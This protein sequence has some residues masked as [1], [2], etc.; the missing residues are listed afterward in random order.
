ML[1]CVLC[2][3]V[4]VLGTATVF[5]LLALLL[6]Y[7]IKEKKTAFIVVYSL[8]VLAN[9]LSGIFI[10]DREI[11][12][13]ITEVSLVS[14]AMALPYLLLK[15]KKRL[16][17]VWF[18]LIICS[19]FDYLESLVISFFTSPSEHTAQIVYIVLYGLTLALILAAYRFAK[20]RIPAD[21]LEQISPTIYVVIF[22]ADYSAYYD[23]MLSQNSGYH[24]EVSNVLKLLSAALI[25]ACFSYIIYRYSSL[26]YKQRESELQLEAELKHYEEM[27]QKNRDIRTFRHDYKNNLYSLKTLIASGRTDEAEKYIDELDSGLAVSENRYATGNYL[28]DAII[29]GKADEA[30]Q[31]GIDI[32]FDGVIP[33]SGI[34]NNDLCTI[35]S[36]ALD[37][38]V[39]ACAEIAPCKIIINSQITAN[40]ASIRI[41][42]PVKENVE[43]KNN[44]VKTTKN[45]KT[46]HGIG[47]SNIKKAAKKYSGYVELSCEDRIFTVEIGLMLK[48]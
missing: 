48:N 44:S 3:A 9:L 16:T 23:V 35:L 37:N 12:E 27:V 5:S 42:N 19:T 13:L 38:A 47:I 21:F 8:F 11:V 20:P 14:A 31:Q 26:S 46:N 7:E 18:G 34:S 4:F 29:S 25:V 45:D 1:T 17:F 40:G 39:R 24:A 15:S 33:E 28:A 6:G 2:T 36:N 32:I 41:S 22:F 43:I 30:A 10:A